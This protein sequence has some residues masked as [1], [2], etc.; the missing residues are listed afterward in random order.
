MQARLSR[1]DLQDNATT[2]ELTHAYQNYLRANLNDPA[3]LIQV[4][5][6]RAA[7]LL[8]NPATFML[9]ML[10]QQFQI[11]VKD[12]YRESVAFE[13][14]F[15]L[16]QHLQVT[17]LNKK[18]K[19]FEN[20]NLPKNQQLVDSYIALSNSLAK[21]PWTEANY[22]QNLAITDHYIAQ[23]DK[24]RV[25]PNLTKED[26]KEIEKSGQELDNKLYGKPPIS[27]TLRAAICGVIGALV[28]VA[29]GIVV[30]TVSSLWLGGFA[31]LP[32]ALLTGFKGGYLGVTVGLAIASAGTGAN[33]GFFSGKQ[34]QAE[35]AAQKDLQARK[36]D[37][38]VVEHKEAIEASFKGMRAG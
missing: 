35:Y 9:P 32:A 28:G 29:L 8:A 7:K 27:P 5:R 16:A 12:N 10:N 3:L 1:L 20:L 6:A 36:M 18:I 30:G 38:E 24:M 19:D 4:D 15:Q 31:T 34:K 37:P 23:V 22:Y 11:R 17:L 33:Y 14:E 13:N 2:A 21:E 26:I 25:H